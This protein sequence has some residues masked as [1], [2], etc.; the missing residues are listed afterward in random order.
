LIVILGAGVSG[1]SVAYHLKKKNKDFII[2]EKENVPGGLCRNISVDGYVF[3]YT[4]HFL[5][6]KTEYV[7]NLA[8]KLVPDI[9]KTKRNSFIYLDKRIVPYPIQSNIRYLSLQSRIKSLLSSFFERGEEPENLEEWFVYNFGKELCRIFFSPYNQKLWNYPI[10]KISPDFLRCYVP[11]RSS[12]YSEKVGEYNAEFFYPEKG[13]GKLISSLAEDIKISQ[14][15]VNRVDEDYVYFGG[16]RVRFKN[17]VSTIA[18]PEFLKIFSVNGKSY[19]I[20]DGSLVWN[21]VFCINIGLK[22]NFSFVNPTKKINQSFS[23][24]HWMYFPESK[25]P[26]YR[27]GSLSNV[28]SSMAPKNHS[29]LWVEISYRKNKPNRSI[30]DTVIKNL[31][32]I[33]ILKEETIECIS[34]LD[35]PYAYPIYNMDR[36]RI[37]EDIKAFLGKYNI[38]LAGRFGGWKYSYMEESV[39]EGKEIAEELCRK[40]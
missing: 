29:S 20:N 2:I 11:R 37:L 40:S 3:N 14:G 35:I 24:F 8:K 25:Y 18:L 21:S 27:I 19:K 30:V 15:K 31:E 32:Q 36:K 1:L 34:L 33:G 10:K 5:H 6:C 7:R 39:L 16:K 9:K 13:I 38:I 28:S 26:F 23:K 12:L 17:L 22:G 4:G